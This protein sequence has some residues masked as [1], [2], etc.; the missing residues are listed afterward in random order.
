MEKI[1]IKPVI[2]NNKIISIEIENMSLP[3]KT[4][5]VIDDLAQLVKVLEDFVRYID[6]EKLRNISGQEVSGDE[7]KEKD[8]RGLVLGELSDNQAVALGV[9]AESKEITREKFVDKLKGKFGKNDFNGWDLGGLLRSITVKSRKHGY[10]TL[11]EKEWRV[12]GNDYECFYHL[13]KDAYRTV[14]RAA[15]E[16]K[17]K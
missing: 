4:P 11:Y 13:A 5:L 2:Q 12:V 10:S 15:L 17:T 16:E 7:W 14:I 3:L 9:L 8:L 1:S 6:V